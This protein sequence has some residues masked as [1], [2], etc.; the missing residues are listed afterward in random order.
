MSAFPDPGTIEWFRYPFVVAHELARAWLTSEM[1]L[2]LAPNTLDAYAR[3]LDDFL[4]FCQRIA[5]DPA[6]ATR[7][8]LARY[9][10]DLRQRPC[11]R[12]RRSTTSLTPAVGLSNATLQQRLTAV[13]LFFDFLMEEGQRAENP[14]GR[15]RYTPG[16][17]F[18]A[19]RERA[20]VPRWQTIPW[21]PTDEEWRHFLSVAYSASLR[22]RCMIAL[23]YDT[24]LRREE[25]C[26]L[27]SDDLDPAHRMVRVRAETAK[28]SRQRTVPY[29]ATTGE[30]LRIYLAH[31]HSLSRARGNCFSPNRHATTPNP[32]H[33]G[34]GR[35]WCTSWPSRQVSRSS[36]P[37]RFATCV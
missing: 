6:K 10:G 14:V 4:A 24:G 2:G 16:K 35:K 8:D 33:C 20:L 13:R 25:L 11:M 18:G 5:V 22:T 21:I 15:G 26:S 29:S 23:A 37:T 34:R 32:S 9:V 17:A 19:D 28:G 27:R 36:P 12:P 30:L 1:L 7:G 31:R 3:G